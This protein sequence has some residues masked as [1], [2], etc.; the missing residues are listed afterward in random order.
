[1]DT[2][3]N[4][5]NCGFILMD[6][7]FRKTHLL[8]QASFVQLIPCHDKISGIRAQRIILVQQ[9]LLSVIDCDICL[10]LFV[11]STYRGK[12]RSLFRL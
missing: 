2:V 11:C 8:K 1:M 4:A 6:L 9:H 5:V 10:S 7:A 12:I 3:K